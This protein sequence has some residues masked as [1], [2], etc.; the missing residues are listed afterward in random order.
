MIVP[1]EMLKE[2]KEIFNLVLTK[3]TRISFKEFLFNFS[4]L[5]SGFIFT[6]NPT[7]L[8]RTNEI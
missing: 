4:K 7:Q 5:F 3:K 6:V 8:E 2:I 1:L